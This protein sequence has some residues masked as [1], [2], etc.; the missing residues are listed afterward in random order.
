[1][2]PPASAGGYNHPRFTRMALLVKCP[3]CD[4]RHRAA[5]RFQGR[6]ATCRRCGRTIVIDGPPIPDFDVF[7]SYSSKDKLAAD[8]TCAAMETRHLRCWIAPRDIVAGADW[9]SSIIGSSE[10]TPV[11]VPH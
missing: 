8:A 3:F 9:A 5:A 2:G 7:I 1:A 11:M 6:Q 4:A 10:T